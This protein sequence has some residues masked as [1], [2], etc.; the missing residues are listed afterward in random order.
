[1]KTLRFLRFLLSQDYYLERTGD[2]EEVYADY[3][4]ESGPF[5]AKVWLWSQIFKLC[6]ELIRKY[7]IWRGIMI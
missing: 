5:Q 4:E 3:L 7:I 1:M 2:L 6:M